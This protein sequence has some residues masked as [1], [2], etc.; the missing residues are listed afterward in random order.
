MF[1]ND[2]SSYNSAPIQQTGANEYEKIYTVGAT[3]SDVKEGAYTCSPNFGDF[4]SP[5][6]GFTT[7]VGTISGKLC[8]FAATGEKVML[9]CTLHASAEAKAVTFAHSENPVSNYNKFA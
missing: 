7:V 9:T 3:F 2:S 5:I 1:L 8:N 6:A 4:N